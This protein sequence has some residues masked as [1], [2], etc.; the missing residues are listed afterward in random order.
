MQSSKTIRKVKRKPY[1]FRTSYGQIAKLTFKTNQVDPHHKFI[2]EDFV[3]DGVNNPRNK[4][5]LSCKS[6]GHKGNRQWRKRR[7][8]YETHSKR[9]QNKKELKELIKA[10]D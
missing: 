6:W 9:Q 8:R 3:R 1:E 4:D 7:D 5:P 10:I 2:Y